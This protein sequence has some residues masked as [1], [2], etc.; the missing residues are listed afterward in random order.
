MNVCS[1]L[2]DGLGV[3]LKETATLI[4]VKLDETVK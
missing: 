1:A 4:A 3:A 2:A